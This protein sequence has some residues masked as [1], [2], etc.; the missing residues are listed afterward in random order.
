MD[1][2]GY[3]QLIFKLDQ[4]IRKYYI[5]ALIR[6]LLY[7]IGTILAMFLVF[8]V[9]EYYFYFST[10]VRKFFFYT[11]I[12]T[13][14]AAI[15][16]WVLDPLIRYLKLGKTISHEEAAV[17]IGNH[18]SDV[19]DKLLNI[20]Q[21]KR[22]ADTTHQQ[23]LVLASIEQKTKSI[24]LVPFKAAI[25]LQK[26]KKYAKYALPPLALLLFILFAAPSILK[27]GTK[28]IIQNNKTFER[29]APFSFVLDNKDLKVI[30]NHDFTINVKTEGTV[31]PNEMYVIVD[32]FLYKMARSEENLFTYTFKNVQ[33]DQ[34]F[35]LQSGNF[36]SNSY[37]L[38]VIKKPNLQH[39]SL[40]LTFPSYLGRK[41]E[42]LESIGDISIPEG[43]RVQWI[44]DALY[45]D[46]LTFQFADKKALE[47]ALRSGD[48]EYKFD[49]R[50]TKDE[51][52]TVFLSNDQI[53]HPDS[54]HYT[55]AVVK[56]QYPTIAAEQIIDSTNKTSIYFVGNAS[57]DY[58]IKSLTFNYTITHEN[59]KMEPNKV[60][61]LGSTGGRES[62]F[63]HF[64]DLN[65]VQLT[66]GDKITYF[67]E[68]FDNDGVNGSKS[69]KSVLMTFEKPSL[70]QLENQE[71]AND[72]LLKDELKDALKK[73]DKLQEQ[74]K[75]LR[76]K[77]LQEKDMSW[78]D[79]KE[80]E[81]LLEEQKKIQ[82]QIEKAKE[83]LEENIKNREE[84]QKDSETMEKEEK[85]QEMF[86]K[87]A[88]PETKELMD[89]IQ[90]LM[91]ELEKEDAVQMLEQFEQ[92]NDSKQKEMER[93]LDLY[94]Q[95]EMEK[96]IQDQIKDLEKLA[97]QQEKLAE[98][99]EKQQESKEDLMK[100][101]EE[102]NKKMEDIKKKQEELEKQNKELSPP[103]KMDEKAEEKMDEISDE[104]QESQEQMQKNDSQ[105]ASK[106]QKSAAKKMKQ[107]ASDMKN[108]M[109][110]GNSD[111]AGE[112]I[113]TI[114]QL[115]E[116]L[117]TLSFDQENLINE[118]SP[119]FVTSPLFPKSIRE[120]YKLQNDFKI[121]ED[122]LVALS[123]RNAD[124]E[125]FVMD[126]VHEVK[127]NLKESIQFLEERD[128]NN[129]QERQR[130]TMKNVNDLALMLNESL[131]NA[132]KQ[133][134]SGMP[135]SQM[136][137]KPG[138]KGSGNSGG[139]PVDKITEGQQGLNE[140]L[141]QMKEKMDKE[142][143]EG[144][145]A[146]D[147]AQAAAQQAALRKA[148]EELQ[149]EKKEQ[150]KGS[151]ALEEIIKNMDKIETELVNK[152]LNTETLRRMKDIE[153]KL[154]EAEKAE[155]QREL[156]EKR[157]SETAKDIQREV[158]KHIQEYLKKRQ[159][160]TEMYRSVSPT[161]KPF[162]KGLVDE[163]YQSVKNKK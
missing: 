51:S 134:A 115:L 128:V 77:L 49:K 40:H 36:N 45:T 38:K 119:V 138:G 155:R 79:K 150:G 52:Y 102:L 37:Q 6:G 145:K 60:V 73:M 1:I 83:K 41:G 78:Q 68:V 50:I 127:Y 143:K 61:P 2:S 106:S 82:E 4:F 70:E 84:L 108:A 17:I 139:K 28:R 85:L 148:L 109:Q 91:Q 87:A 20:L 98:K 154:L 76:D 8:N 156:D 3:N 157:K 142:G 118:M 56:D 123:N 97:D 47:P 104:M 86:E 113:K 44:F 19:K 15:M 23:G 5:N 144:G 53:A 107:Q 65:K 129:G 153:T 151:E 130:R 111:Q 133:Q 126:K 136:C 146:K 100:K 159:A 18:F 105:G 31:Q 63:E 110:S 116:N 55:I 81:K 162:Y 120:Q 16:Y 64:L 42:I 21:L 99:T 137:N 27:D 132:Q 7:S 25:D 89:K 101:Q 59:G 57:D 90:E 122:T 125:T 24:Q 34:D 32:D 66:S 141:K 54:L 26:N 135:G 72:E 58:G 161:L 67:F 9:L 29:V 147:F 152:R 103:K 121:I 163:Y 35:I 74:M 88:D 112:D 114:R 80:M 75:K 11:F 95:L 48:S 13:S 93:L 39:F 10:A 92:N 131:E 94:K 30:Q 22:Q 14:G 117:V 12:L 158:P 33:K 62:K 43:T 124:I 149:G 160:E 96:N 71:Q 140:S 69:S 46:Q